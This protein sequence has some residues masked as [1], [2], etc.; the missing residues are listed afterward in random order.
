MLFGYYNLP[1][2]VF[3]VALL[4]RRSKFG[5]KVF[6]LY[7]PVQQF[8]NEKNKVLYLSLRQEICIYLSLYQK[9][10][11][12]FLGDHCYKPVCALYAIATFLQPVLRN[13][14]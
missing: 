8:T 4:N 11:Y 10:M 13:L 12:V 5:Y 14:H 3:R 2:I 6:V 9:V 7:I 1:L